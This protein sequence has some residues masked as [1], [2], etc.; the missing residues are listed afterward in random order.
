MAIKIQAEVEVPLVSGKT[1]KL[2]LKD[3]DE[4]EVRMP[5]SLK[6]ER[7]KLGDLEAGVAELKQAS[8]AVAG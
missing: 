5:V 6:L 7:M 1:A 8:E 4:V 2:R 3:S